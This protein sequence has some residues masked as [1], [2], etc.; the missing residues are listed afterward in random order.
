[1][2]SEHAG[3]RAPRQQQA[4][5]GHSELR[6]GTARERSGIRVSQD[7]TRVR[8]HPNPR[9]E[10]W[11]PSRRVLLAP[12]FYTRL[13]APRCA[14]AASPP[15][16]PEVLCRQPDEGS[17]TCCAASPL[18]F[19][20]SGGSM[21]VSKCVLCQD[22][23]SCWEEGLSWQNP[24]PPSMGLRSPAAPSRL[25]PQ[26]QSWSRGGERG[27]TESLGL[28]LPRHR[29]WDAKRSLSQADFNPIVGPQ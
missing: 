23:P 24:A 29:R 18:K 28:A 4:N 16:V 21:S 7:G 25:L 20:L 8:H 2:T 1:M 19:E 22:S 27:P 3:F 14:C 12:V 5:V 13:P 11:V 15:G 10:L 9:W 26:A 17:P 6:E